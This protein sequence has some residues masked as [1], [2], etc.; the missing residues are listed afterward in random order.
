MPATTRS[1]TVLGAGILGLWQALTLARAGHRVR[2]VEVSAEPFADAASFYGGVML[3]P[4]REAETAPAML[5]QLGREGVALWRSFY[6]ALKSNGSIVIA[7]ARDRGELERFARRTQG[8][9]LVDAAELGALEPDLADRFTSALY[10]PEEAHMPAPA[11]LAFM[12]AE[13]QRAGVEMIFGEAAAPEDGETIV[14]CRGL[15]A[16]DVLPD[17]R[18]VRGE[19]ALIRTREISLQRPVQLLHPRL[20]LYIVPWDDGLYMVGA[21]LVESEDA[22]PVSV[23]SALEL[24]G[25]AYAVHPAFGEAEVVDLGAGVRP[26]FP[27]N[28]PRA[29]LRDDG[30]RILVNGAY[31]HGFL[32]APVLARAVADYIESGN[33]SALLTTGAA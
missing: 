29:V 23:R 27:D 20:P 13:V 9:R 24:L 3:A 10:F 4:E 5:R 21:T 14:D 26:A 2:L 12:L 30:R 22:G 32:L 33:G 7:A 8:H 16:R 17:L 28:V 18:G 15:A 25:G 11:A 19:R 6:P 1:I 31:R